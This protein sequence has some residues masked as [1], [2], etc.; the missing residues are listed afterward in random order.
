MV[1][2]WVVV[3]RDAGSTP[4]FRVFFSTGAL[5]AKPYAFQYRTWELTSQISIDLFD[6]FRP[7]LKL[8][9]RGQTLVR[10]LPLSESLLS[11]I[12]DLTRFN[13]PV[14]VNILSKYKTFGTS[15]SNNVK[16][17]SFFHKF[18]NTFH[19]FY[20]MFSTK[21]HQQ[22]S[23]FYKSFFR[24]SVTQDVN[25]NED[26]PHILIFHFLNIRQY[27]PSYSAYIR[28]IT[29]HKK[30]IFFGAFFDLRLNKHIDFNFFSALHY[31]LTLFSYSSFSSL[32]L[33]SSS[34]S[35]FSP[36]QLLNFPT[37]SIKTF[38]FFTSEHLSY[39]FLSTFHPSTSF[40]TFFSNSSMNSLFTPFSVPSINSS[41]NYAPEFRKNLDQFLNKN[42]FL[43][44][45]S[46]SNLFC[47][48]PTYIIS[49]SLL[50]YQKIDNFFEY[51]RSR[52]LRT[53]YSK[54]YDFRQISRVQTNY[55]DSFLS[56]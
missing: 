19:F 18:H 11:W 14:F 9:F 56:S 28:T 8:Q 37:S 7:I 44:F 10:I 36:F 27:S 45:F 54:L 22:K 34:F 24:N 29:R 35:I 16:F 2:C 51:N 12:G 3:P 38:S 26:A 15:F 46:F 49:S 21:F 50:C 47:N 53:P 52:T 5:T 30:I 41:F 1:E 43:N 25:L 6:F 55:Y 33:K 32:I 17:F 13:L 40:S 48:V 23:F 31:S 39:K 20:S 4:V 42:F